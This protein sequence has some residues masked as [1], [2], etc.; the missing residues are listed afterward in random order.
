MK[1]ETLKKFVNASVKAKSKRL[2]Q[3]V[4]AEEARQSLEAEA[5]KIPEK[6]KKLTVSLVACF[7]GTYFIVFGMYIYQSLSN[8]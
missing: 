4:T 1:K 2:Y 8:Y 5:L 6:I 7:V 3:N